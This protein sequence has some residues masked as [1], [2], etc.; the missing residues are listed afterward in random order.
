MTR[1]QERHADRGKV[2]LN[3][4]HAR[5]FADMHLNI[6]DDRLLTLT[7]APPYKCKE[8]C[9]AAVRLTIMRRT[10]LANQ[11]VVFPLAASPVGTPLS[12]TSQTSAFS[13]YSHG[14]GDLKWYV[15]RSWG[16]RAS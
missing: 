8:A 14:Y 6:R 9:H 5:M 12:H 11:S 10:L 4:L 7:L 3:S 15:C 16:A 13:D 2:E 1:R